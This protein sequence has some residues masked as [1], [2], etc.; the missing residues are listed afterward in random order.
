MQETEGQGYQLV[1]QL[2]HLILPVG[3]SQ[4]AVLAFRLYLRTAPLLHLAA[5]QV[6][7][8]WSLLHGRT[9]LHL[10]SLLSQQ[11]MLMQLHPLETGAQQLLQLAFLQHSSAPLRL[12]ELALQVAADVV[13][14]F[15]HS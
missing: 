3:C 8:T 14:S 12:L 15:P 10:P 2:H 4:A 9:V 5:L 7:A 1:C 6:L 11:A 13:P